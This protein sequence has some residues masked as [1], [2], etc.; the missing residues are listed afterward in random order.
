MQYNY[1]DSYC[2]AATVRPMIN[3]PQFPEDK[4][5]SD[6]EMYERQLLEPLH[7][8]TRWPFHLLAPGEAV[9]VGGDAPELAR[10]R[11]AVYSAARRKGHRYATR[12][13]SPGMMLVIR[14]AVP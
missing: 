6:E 12:S 14:L 11:V 5:L 10:C 4:I 13:E 2:N 1:I 7:H 3:R 8:R 9:R